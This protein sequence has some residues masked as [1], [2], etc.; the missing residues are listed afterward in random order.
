M[1]TAKTS[2][3]WQ[4]LWFL[5]PATVNRVVKASATLELMEKKWDKERRQYKEKDLACERR[6]VSALEAG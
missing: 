4:S 3:I 5:I 2:T 1:R 6:K